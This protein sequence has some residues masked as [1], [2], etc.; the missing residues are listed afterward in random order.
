MQQVVN[1]VFT[2]IQPSYEK[3]VQPNKAR[4]KKMQIKGGGQDMAVIIYSSMEKILATAIQVILDLS[5]SETGRRTHKFTWI[6]VIK[7]FTIEL[8]SQPFLEHHLWFYIFFPLALLGCTLFSQ[9]G[10]FCIDITSFCNCIFIMHH[11]GQLWCFLFVFFLI[12]EWCTT[13]KKM[14]QSKFDCFDFF[15]LHNTDF[16]A[17]TL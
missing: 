2:S 16:I 5:P 4:W 12:Q 13:V 17:F 9:L 1:A 7:M 15:L 10:C 3:S 6:I 8:L 11:C 14:L